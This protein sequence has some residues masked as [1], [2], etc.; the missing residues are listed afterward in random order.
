MLIASTGILAGA[1][2]CVLFWKDIVLDKKQVKG[3][4][5]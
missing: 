4:V 3:L 5:V 2:I 1:F